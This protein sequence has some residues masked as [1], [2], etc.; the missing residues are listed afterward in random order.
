MTSQDELYEHRFWLEILSDH[1]TFIQLKLAVTETELHEDV[2]GLLYQ[3]TSDLDDAKEGSVDLEDIKELVADI[4][5][6]KE[7]LLRRQILGKVDLS[8]PP[9]FINHM[10]NELQAYQRILDTLPEIVVEHPLSYHRLWLKDAEGHADSIITELDA[11]EMPKRKQLKK[12]K[13]KFAALYAKADEFTGYLRATNEQFPA[14]LKLTLDAETHIRVFMVMLKEVRE[15]VSS[16]ELL[17]T[18]LPLMADHM[19]REERYYLDKL[20][21]SRK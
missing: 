4:R 2:Q 13:K 15:M 1:L 16:K 3:I 17:G 14:L 6:F 21:Q 8:L 10:L 9:T 18:F 7:D 5:L 12:L 11:V 20:A 19:L